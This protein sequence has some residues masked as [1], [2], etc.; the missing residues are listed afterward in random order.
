MRERRRK[1]NIIM[2][3]IYKTN[4]QCGI[5]SGLLYIPVN[6]CRFCFGSPCKKATNFNKTNEKFLK[7]N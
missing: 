2:K 3:L 6:I 7:K 5:I 1:N 4:E